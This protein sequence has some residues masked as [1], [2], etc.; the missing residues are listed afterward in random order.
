M[1]YIHDAK[2]RAELKSSMMKQVE[3]LFG[4]LANR[5]GTQSV[6]F[7]CTASNA[8]MSGFGDTISMASKG[9]EKFSIEM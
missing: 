5:V 6:A 3:E 9:A 7:F 4:I 1:S 8:D 2:E